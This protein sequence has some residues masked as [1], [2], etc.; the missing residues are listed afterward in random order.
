MEI[1]HPRITEALRI[2]DALDLPGPLRSK[3]AGLTLLA[4][5]GVG[6]DTPWAQANDARKGMAHGIRDFM[7]TVYGWREAATEHSFQLMR[8]RCCYRWWPWAWC[9]A[10]PTTPPC[11]APGLVPVLR[12]Y[13]TPL[14]A[15]TV[16]AF[17]QQQEKLRLAVSS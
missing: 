6:P 12:S 5:A 13:G 7:H 17:R 3:L 1:S 2:L 9:C 15:A 10:T 16:S 14:W 8:G 11:R 4:L